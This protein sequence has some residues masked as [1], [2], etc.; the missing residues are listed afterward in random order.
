M[1]KNVVLSQDSNQVPSREKKSENFLSKALPLSHW[2]LLLNDIEIKRNIFKPIYLVSK[3]W[4]KTNLVKKS[5]QNQI[6]LF[7]YQLDRETLL[8]M[9]KMVIIYDLEYDRVG[10][11]HTEFF[12]VS[13]PL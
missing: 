13:R 12:W 6:N 10:Q 4:S 2:G 1:A 8:L 5:I 9:T 7:F 3:Y 11:I